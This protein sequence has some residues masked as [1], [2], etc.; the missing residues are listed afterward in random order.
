MYTEAAYRLWDELTDFRITQPDQAA[1]HLMASLCEQV[2][3]W[4]ATW[5]GAICFAGD[6]DHDPLKGWRV[7][8]VQALRP[9]APHPDARHFEEILEIWDKREIDPSFLLPMKGVGHFRSYSLRRELEPGWFEGPFYRMH[10]GSVGTHDAVFVAF[11][12]NQHCESHFGF[13]SSSTFTDEHID[14]LCYVLRGIKW[15]HRQLMMSRGLLMASAP[16]TTTE[17]KVLHLLLTKASEKEI[18]HAMTMATS[19]AHQHVTAIFR[20]FGVSSRA[21]LMSLW[22]SPR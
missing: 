22:L 13:Y 2:G 21:G 16:L 1:A 19:T 7:G 11:P 12:L 20:K 15:F 17:R 10:Y 6:A 8:A 9:V 5:A 3:A 4:N 14:L 18:A